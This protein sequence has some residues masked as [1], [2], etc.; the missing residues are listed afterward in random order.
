MHPWG[1]SWATARQ[2]D[3]WTCPTRIL[4]F[5][6]GSLHWTQSC[7]P[8][9]WSQHLILTRLWPWNSSHC[10]NGGQTFQEWGGVI[11]FPLP[12]ST[13]RVSW[14]PCPPNDPQHSPASLLISL[15]QLCVLLLE[16][17]SIASQ[18]RDSIKTLGYSFPQQI[19]WLF[20]F[21]ASYF[22]LAVYIICPK[23][24]RSYF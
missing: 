2:V 11:S 19:G 9:R 8:S 24:N 22:F 1:W 23:G 18:C 16:L 15:F 13:L 5:M 20:Q 10:G 12:G 17:P 14:W 4:K 3:L 21:G 7:I 6:W